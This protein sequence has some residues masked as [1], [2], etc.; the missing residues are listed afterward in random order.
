[1]RYFDA[2]W[3]KHI[4]ENTV[5]NYIAEG[6]AI[7]GVLLWGGK[8]KIKGAR[9]TYDY[10]AQLRVM[11]DV[12]GTYLPIAIDDVRRLM[13]GRWKITSV[14]WANRKIIMVNELPIEEA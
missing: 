12:S 6:E 5:N 8:I 9:R 1:L 2:Y 3:F 11:I 14:T 13:K 4:V 7:A 10:H